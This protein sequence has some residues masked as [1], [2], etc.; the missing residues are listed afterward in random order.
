MLGFRQVMLG[1]GRPFWRA[2]E[3]KND[4]LGRTEGVEDVE[5]TLICWVHDRVGFEHKSVL[6]F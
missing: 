2:E 1:T 6:V 3:N 4:S 5:I